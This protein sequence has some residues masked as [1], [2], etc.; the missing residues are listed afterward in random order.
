MDTSFVVEALIPAQPMHAVCA[1]YLERITETEATVYFN[2]LLE[3]ELLEAVF[4]ADLRRRHGANKWQKMRHDG[5]ARR[6]A[7]R[8]MRDI[9]V[10]WN[11]ALH[12]LNSIVIELHE[13]VPTIPDLM[14]DYGLG[15]ND[16]V[17]TATALRAGVTALVTLDAGFGAVPEAMLQIYTDKS[18]LGA[19]RR[20]RR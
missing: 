5:R 20:F 7:A 10:A 12:A 11:S 19:C 16:A 6:P 9:I 14:S 17:H 1:A 3:A 18:R 15:S 8:L 2:R 4:K 13:A